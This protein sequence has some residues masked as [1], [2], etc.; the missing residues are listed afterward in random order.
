MYAANECECVEKRMMRIGGRGAYHCESLKYNF[1]KDS[2]FATHNF[3][4][5][6]KR[7]TLAKEYKSYT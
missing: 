4:L 5:L 1:K 3:N 2:T 7:I 6:P